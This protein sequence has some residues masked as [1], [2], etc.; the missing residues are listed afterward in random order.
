MA[1]AIKE[2]LDDAEEL[3]DM[4]R[5]TIRR[6]HD[7]EMDARNQLKDLKNKVYEAF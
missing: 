4:L 6:H 5:E 2:A 1:D 7:Q 3:R